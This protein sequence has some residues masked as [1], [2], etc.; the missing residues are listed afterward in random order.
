[1]LQFN[2]GSVRKNWAEIKSRMTDEVPLSV[3][4]YV[5]IHRPRITARQPDGT[6]HPGGGVSIL[7]RCGQLLS[8][9]C[10]PPVDLAPGVTTEL[11]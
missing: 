6:M 11:I 10:L 1:M 2:A 4:G 5:W 3:S 8:A 7:V 9:Q